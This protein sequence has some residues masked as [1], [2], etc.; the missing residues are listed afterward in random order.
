MT[1]DTHF[2]K[3]L[4]FLVGAAAVGVAVVTMQGYAWLINSVL[5]GTIIAVVSVPLLRWL[6]RVGLPRWLAFVLTLLILVVLAVAFVLFAMAAVSQLREAIPTYTTQADEL[7]ATIES[8][9][10]GLGFDPSVSQGVLERLDPAQLLAIIVDILESLV[11][12][13]S[14]LVVVV[15]VL[16][17]LLGESLHL[18]T[19]MKELLHQGHAQLARVDAYVRDLQRY[20]GVTAQLSAITGVAA[21]LWLLVLGVDFA[22][23]WGV[24]T[25]LLS[26]IPTVGLF[27]AMIPP[28]LLA[29]LEFGWAKALLVVAGYLLADAVV[30]NV[31]KPKYIGESLN[32]SPVVVI[33]SLI[34]WAAVLG[35][36]GALLGVPLTMAVKE[37]VLE[38]DEESQ[39]VAELMSE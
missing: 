12:A 15:L 2:S 25:F 17:F 28:V 3:T 6:E 24:L 8:A 9:L 38:A 14:N 16:A 18:S 31:I 4:L 26:F 37:L 30:E 33:L 27:L 36:L 7:R 29:L 32:L 20:V 21:T 34:F 35:P 22:V 11:E 10:V 19:K 5:L 39:W 1:K 13:I 23:L